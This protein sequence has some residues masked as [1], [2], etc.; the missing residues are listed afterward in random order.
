MTEMERLEKLVAEYRQ[1]ICDVAHDL[2]RVDIPNQEAVQ[3]RLQGRATKLLHE[4]TEGE[5]EWR[6]GCRDDTGEIER[7]QTCHATVYEVLARAKGC[8][9]THK[10]FIFAQRIDRD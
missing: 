4:T 10:P 5:F 1:F 2:G 3:A 8:H 7:F 6:Y 9:Y